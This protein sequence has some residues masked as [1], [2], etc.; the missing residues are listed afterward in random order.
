MGDINLLS[1]EDS[2]AKPISTEKRACETLTSYRSIA[3]AKQFTQVPA[4]SPSPWFP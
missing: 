2:F 1:I 3:A 4:D